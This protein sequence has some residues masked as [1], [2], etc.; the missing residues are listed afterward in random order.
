MRAVPGLHK[1][2]K[3]MNI[4]LIMSDTFRQDHLG[5]YGNRNISTP[6]LDEFA[7]QCTRVNNAYAAS[8]P[9]MPNRADLLTGTFTFPHS[10]WGPLPRETVT[11]G[12][13]LKNAGYTTAAVVDTPFFL[14]DRYGYDQGFEDFEWVA[15]QP[16]G[17]FPKQGLRSYRE[18]RYEEDYFAPRTITL[19]EKFLE[20]SYTERFFL[21]VDVWDP[22][23]PWDPPSWYVEPYYRGYEGQVIEPCY[24]RWEDY[25][26]TKED[27]DIAHACYCGEITMVDHWIGRL[28]DKV[29]TMGLLD[30]TMIVFTSDHGFYFGEHGFFGKV[31]R[32]PPDGYGPFSYSPLYEETARIPLL[33]YVPGLTPRQTDAFVQPP[34][35]TATLLDLAGVEPPPGIQ[36]RSFSSVL[37]GEQDTFRDFVVTSMPLYNPGEKTRMV[38]D[39]ERRIKEPLPSTITTPEW[40]FLYAMED[41]PAEL[42]DR[43]RDPAQSRNVLS[44]HFAVAEELHQRFIEFL[45][46]IGTREL[47]LSRRMKLKA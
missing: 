22:H 2:E 6:R 46:E 18:R 19:A 35:V 38:D 28:L 44:E 8:F 34:D 7:G 45:K 16:D 24:G 31:T 4:I 32:E 47:Y 36:G 9:T 39:F 14:R 26:L 40:S 20:R 42:Y 21:Y 15:G 29:G 33:V 11:L 27:V 41:W 23:E 25:G 1:G 12:E 37:K 3:R 17:H 13:V 30:D 10:G 5:C 43:R